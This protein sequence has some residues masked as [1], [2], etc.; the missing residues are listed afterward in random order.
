MFKLNDY[1]AHTTFCDGRDTP[2][3]MVAE[4]YRRG[5][6]SVGLSSHSYTT[7]E[8]GFG[9]TRTLAACYRREVL[10]LKEKYRGRMNVFLGIEQDVFSTPAEGYDY[11][12]GGAHYI[13]VGDASVAVDMSPTK[14]EE[15]V[16]E[17][18]AG[19][20]MRYVAA[21]Y[22]TAAKIPETT[23]ADIVA[24]FDL[25][26][27]FNEGNRYFDENSPAY[28]KIA[29]EALERAAVS[30]PIF[31]LNSGG[32]RRGR[33][34]RVYPDAFL[35]REIRRLGCD[36]I[37]SSDSHDKSSLGFMFDEMADFAKDCGFKYAKYL[38][39][40]GFADYKL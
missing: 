23:G 12:I 8:G 35:L 18:F 33:R 1:H 26:T 37:F 40:E 25:V 13:G 24:H 15:G 7:F 4:A 11:I 20:W 29:I 9:M 32:V 21:Y 38:T 36:I 3:E 19:D 39:P 30:R 2:A 16:R 17:Y 27:K 34:S 22:E 28:R 14:V 6:E 5:F 31:E 10:S